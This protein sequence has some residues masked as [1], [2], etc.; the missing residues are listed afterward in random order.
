M[1]PAIE[2]VVGGEL[3][4]LMVEGHLVVHGLDFRQFL[5]GHPGDGQFAGEGFERTQHFV[6][7][8]DITCRKKNHAC[9]LVLGKRH[10]AFSRENLQ[11]FAQR[12]P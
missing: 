4:T 5:V 1:D 7:L 8:I 11:D 6:E 12:R 3:A 10:V 2:R 9:S